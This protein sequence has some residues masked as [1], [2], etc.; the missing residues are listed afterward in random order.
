MANFKALPG[1]EGEPYIGE[2]RPLAFSSRPTFWL[3]TYRDGSPKMRHKYENGLIVQ[4]D[5]AFNEARERTHDLRQRMSS[6]WKTRKADELQSWNGGGDGR[7]TTRST[8]G[9]GRLATHSTT[10]KGDG[11]GEVI[12]VASYTGRRSAAESNTMEPAVPEESPQTETL[13]EITFCDCPKDRTPK[14]HKKKG[15]ARSKPSPVNRSEGR[16]ISS[17]TSTADLLDRCKSCSACGNPKVAL[18]NREDYKRQVQMDRASQRGGHSQTGTPGRKKVANAPTTVQHPQEPEATKD[19]ARNSTGFFARF[20]NDRDSSSH[21]EP[22]PDIPQKR[23]RN[24]QTRTQRTG[25]L[26]SDTSPSSIA[27][28]RQSAE[29]SSLHDDSAT[30]NL[31]DRSGTQAIEAPSTTGSDG[32]IVDDD[33]DSPVPLGRNSSVQFT[34]DSTG[35]FAQ[36]SQAHVEEEE[37]LSH[38][39]GG[40]DISNQRDPQPVHESA[41][42][43]LMQRAA[44]ADMGSGVS[45]ANGQVGLGGHSTAVSNPHEAATSSQ[46][47]HLPLER[48]GNVALRTYAEDPTHGGNTTLGLSTDFSYT[49]Q[50]T[51]GGP[52]DGPQQQLYPTSNQRNANTDGQ[53]QQAH[54]RSSIDHEQARQLEQYATPA[55]SDGHQHRRASAVPEQRAIA[56]TPAPSAESATSSKKRSAPQEDV[57]DLTKSDDDSPSSAN[58]RQASQTAMNS[59]EQEREVEDRLVKIRREKKRLQIKKESLSVEEGLIDLDEEEDDLLEQKRQLSTGRVIKSEPSGIVKSEQ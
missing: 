49:G 18:K 52:A 6:E 25:S 35:Q 46:Q 53:H 9:S 36:D 15:K 39:S 23:K 4:Q 21:E 2:F 16:N 22:L 43:R 45:D 41:N 3:E 59:A 56:N 30:P 26:A 33:E 44:T 12:A 47:T 38:V 27:V 20:A 37:P 11:T 57:V 19:L 8:S 34:R 48:D 10:A 40:K 51:Q 42:G 58:D 24:H 17:P 14:Q 32:R 1:Q 5:A 7:R 29:E 54:S 31:D 13:P 28:Q 55:P 50:D